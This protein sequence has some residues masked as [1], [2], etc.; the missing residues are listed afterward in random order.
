MRGKIS[1]DLNTLED[2]HQTYLWIPGR[3]HIRP[4]TDLIKDKLTKI[5]DLNSWSKEYFGVHLQDALQGKYKYSYY[6]GKNEYSYVVPE[7]TNH[8]IL[9]FPV[10]FPLPDKTVDDILEKEVL[11]RKGT[12][13]VWYEN[14]KMSVPQIWHV[15]VFWH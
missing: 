9:W 15:Q 6:F 4:N 10:D 14:P 11:K 2:L 8:F 13:Y 5:L 1:S 12:D 7:G 3:Q